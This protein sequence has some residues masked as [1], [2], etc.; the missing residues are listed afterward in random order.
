MKVVKKQRAT[1]ARK[2]KPSFTEVLGSGYTIFFY[3]AH[4]K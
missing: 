3:P 1:G 2:A 4:D